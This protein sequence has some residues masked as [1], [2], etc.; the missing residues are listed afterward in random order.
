MNPNRRVLLR[1]ADEIGVPVL[2]LEVVVGGHLL[3]HFVRPDDELLALGT[4]EL[5]AGAEVLGRSPS[6]ALDPEGVLGGAAD[7]L[8]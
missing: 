2:D 7:L 6:P 1:L 4:E 3:A 8:A 5:I